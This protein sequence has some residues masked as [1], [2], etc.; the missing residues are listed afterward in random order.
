MKR[1]VLIFV[2][3]PPPVTGAT[4]MNKLVTE[5]KL[6]KEA[7]CIEYVKVSYST[8]IN[9]I[10]K[11]RWSKLKIF[12]KTLI[13]LV[14]K[15]PL[16]RPD[17]VYFQISPDDLAF[18]RDAVFV[19]FIKIFRIKILYH[20][21]GQGIKNRANNTIYYYSYKIVFN[22]TNVICLSE[23]LVDDIKQF[24][25]G[26]IFIVPNG[27]PDIQFPVLRLN[28]D[29]IEINL[30]FLSNL[31]KPKGVFDFIDSLEI[32]NNQKIS[33]KGTIVG[34]EG[35]ISKKEL[36]DYINNKKL[37]DKIS[38]LGPKYDIE[39]HKILE[40]SHIF[41]FPTY[42]SVEA[43]PGV[44]LEAMKYSLP[45][46]ATKFA[47]IPDMISDNENGFLVPINSPNIIADKLKYLIKNRNIRIEMGNYSRRKYESNFT[48]GHF[49][50]NLKNAFNES[51]KYK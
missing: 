18:F 14:K 26:K 8:A 49:E 5:S 3:I 19:F 25:N 36:L 24:V 31:I 39:K 28:N 27:Q 1:K 44:I 37:Q 2:K 20:I 12:F 29:L 7:F 51:L 47:A 48:L 50:N 30:L 43:F 15:L 17:L 22:N 41:V 23:I 21:R 10:G 40:S 34:N 45:V 35:D 32:L 16:F 11:L 33:F 4:L 13:I 38:Y 9:E 46:I 42:Y 6:L